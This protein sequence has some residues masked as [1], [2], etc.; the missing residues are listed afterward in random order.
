MAFFH[1]GVLVWLACLGLCVLR[2]KR[3]LDGVERYTTEIIG[4]SLQLLGSRENQPGS[5]QEKQQLKPQTTALPKP[6]PRLCNPTPA[7]TPWR[8]TSPF[9]S[10]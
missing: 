2:M 10:T 1:A 8:T 5:E 6:P 7:L 3:H 4:D 9:K